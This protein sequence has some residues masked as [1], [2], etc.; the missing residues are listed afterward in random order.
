MRVEGARAH[1]LLSPPDSRHDVL[2]ALLRDRVETLDGEGRSAVEL[3][4]KKVVY[5]SRWER[6]VTL[7]VVRGPLSPEGE[8]WPCALKLRLLPRSSM[9]A[10]P[11]A[12][13]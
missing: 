1:V 7:P 2:P 6:E 9:T 10:S 8:P 5:G 11:A 13:T 12:G 4:T 3:I